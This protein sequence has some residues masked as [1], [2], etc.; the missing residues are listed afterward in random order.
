MSN[1]A[2]DKLKAF[3]ENLHGFFTFRN[4]AII[5]LVDSISANSTAQSTVELSLNPLFPRSHNSIYDAVE[6]V[7]K[8]S[9]PEAAQQERAQHQQGL[10]RIVAETLPRPTQ[11]NFWLFCVDKTPAP[12]PFSKTL[13]D[14]GYVYSPNS[15]PGNKPIA[16]GHSY[17]ALVA[18]PEKTGNRTPPWVVPLNIQRVP[19]NQTGKDIA[20]QQIKM[21]ITDESLP[22]RNELSVQVVDSEYSAVKYLYP[23]AQHEN[24]VT[25][26]RVA[27][28]RIFYREPI[29]TDSPKGRGH[30]LWYGERF[31]LHDESTWG[32]PDET[33]YINHTTKKGRECFVFISAWHNL[34]M[35]GKD[36]FPMHKHPFTLIVI[37]IKYRDGNIMYKNPLWIIALGNHRMEVSIL[38]A[39][40]AYHQRFDVE[41]FFRFGK[42]RLLMVSFQSPKV[43]HEENWLELV[44]LTYVQLWLASPLAKAMPR[45]WE[46]Y[47]VS[48]EIAVLTETAVPASPSAVQRSFE[49]ITR[50]I[51]TPAKPPKRRGYSSGRPIGWS[52][53]RR[54]RC[55][56]IK[57][58]KK[59][60]ESRPRDPP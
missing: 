29:P 5:D 8:P 37:V 33:K 41:H 45:P 51:G 18:L 60:G 55:P 21:L 2:I 35:K 12:R 28:N 31:D 57:K 25:I 44:G 23:V 56:V 6:N 27:G 30:P 38:D 43:E 22:F 53:G 34:L 3:R 7:F 10:M 4:D 13:E 52:P 1:W 46:R 15:T 20:F 49:G 54:K 19:T 11:R 42:N 48:S 16:I 32:G 59:G 40:S 26:V 39:W 50:Q 17:S 24:L 9:N 36:G 47:A 14:R 58:S